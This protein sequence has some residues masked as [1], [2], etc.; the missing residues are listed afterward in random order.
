[1]RKLFRKDSDALDL[2]IL[3][4]AL[5]PS[6]RKPPLTFQ[7]SVSVVWSQALVLDWRMAWNLF[8]IVDLLMGKKSMMSKG[9]A[10]VEMM[11]EESAKEKREF[12]AIHIIELARDR[13]QFPDCKA[14]FQAC[15]NPLKV[16]LS[17]WMKDLSEIQTTTSSLTRY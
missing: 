17:G 12:I 8:V 4:V 9:I 15:S 3:E 11:V 6:L 10:E 1:V 14:L 7:F 5:V 2:W 16:T 13:K